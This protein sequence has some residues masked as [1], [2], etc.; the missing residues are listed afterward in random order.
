MIPG[1][2]AEISFTAENYAISYPFTFFESGWYML[3]INQTML[4]P[5][6][7]SPSTSTKPKADKQSSD[8][9]CQNPFVSQDIFFATQSFSVSPAPTD[10]MNGY[11]IP[12]P[13]TVFA[14]VSKQ[15]PGRLP[16]DPQKMTSHEKLGVGLG[17][18]AGI[19]AFI[20]MVIAIF[21][22]RKRR[23]DFAEVSLHSER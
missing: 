15:Q 4:K 17:V 7:V 8:H 23:R 21:M 10:N 16:I 3:I 1:D 13:Y 9:K 12:S 2:E 11:A 20:G 6:I 19:L 22:L 18:S 5:S 14:E